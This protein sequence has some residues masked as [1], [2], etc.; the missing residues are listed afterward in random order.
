MNE[1]TEGQEEERKEGSQR[2]REGGREEEGRQR[3]GEREGRGEREE[4]KGGR[5]GGCK[6]RQREREREGG[7]DRGGKGGER[8]VGWRE[9]GREEGRGRG[10]EGEGQV[11]E[12][13]LLQYTPTTLL[14]RS[15]MYVPEHQLWLSV[16]RL[17]HQHLENPATETG[18]GDICWSSRRGTPK[19]T[20]SM[21]T[22]SLLKWPEVSEITSFSILRP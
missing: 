1:C 19:L 7:R 17:V 14:W 2:E 3:E 12:G 15:Y 6:E 22:R 20:V 18:S 9:Q 21:E 16:C 4:G 10:R 13:K 8:K 11:N 5:E